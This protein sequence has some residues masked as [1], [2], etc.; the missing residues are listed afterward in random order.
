MAKLGRP[1]LGTA[2]VDKLEGAEESKQRLATVLRTL[3][4]ELSIEE[5]C[6]ELALSPAQVHRLRDR[7]LQG[8]LSALEPGTPGRPPSQPPEEA[9]LIQE[10]EQTAQRLK[11]ELRAAQL[12]E[13]IAILMPHLRTGAGG[14]KKNRARRRR[15]R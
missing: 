10:L 2:H 13:E 14:S 7:A 4:G 15:G 6:A 8:A 5:A 11:I 9:A 3:T 1:P 12:R